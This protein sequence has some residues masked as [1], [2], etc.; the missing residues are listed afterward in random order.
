MVRLSFQARRCAHVYRQHTAQH[1]ARSRWWGGGA[2]EEVDLFVD[3]S[4]VGDAVHDVAGASGADAHEV[5]LRGDAA[6][7][8]EAA[9]T[10]DGGV[11][12]RPPE[13]PDFDV[14]AQF[15][16]FPAAPAI[17]CSLTLLRPVV[18]GADASDRPMRVTRGQGHIG[19]GL[20]PG[21]DPGFQGTTLTAE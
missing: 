16:V 7:E 19:P 14:L 6:V 18:R 15:K 13:P 10:G 8:Q 20:D 5:G 3:L 4:D 21:F 1:E 11:G 17:R 2:H 12:D 9:V